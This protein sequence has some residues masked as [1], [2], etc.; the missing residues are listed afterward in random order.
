MTTTIE[1]TQEV[2]LGKFDGKFKVLAASVYNSSQVYFGCSPEQAHRLGNAVMADYGKV[3]K[4]AVIEQD[5]TKKYS[6]I[7]SVSSTGEV[8]LTHKDTLK[9]SGEATP[10]LCIAR[11]CQQIDSILKSGIVYQETR[12]KL[13]KSLHNWLFEIDAE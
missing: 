9:A 12:T 2:T 5:E 10:S 6:S 11:A 8:K 3:M 7:G 13:V 1:N 4:N